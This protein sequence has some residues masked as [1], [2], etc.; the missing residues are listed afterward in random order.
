MIDWFKNK[1]RDF[2]RW[3]NSTIIDGEVVFQL[4]NRIGI[5]PTR[6]G[7]SEKALEDT[8]EHLGT[9]FIVYNPPE[10]IYE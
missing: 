10:V 1:W 9:A 2:Q 8:R 3:R 7:L 4:D 5:L 6:R